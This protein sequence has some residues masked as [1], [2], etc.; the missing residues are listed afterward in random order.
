MKTNM[1]FHS[2]EHIEKEVN[3]LTYSIMFTD[4]S[5]NVYSMEIADLIVRCNVEIESLAKEIYRKYNSDDDPQSAGPCIS[6]L[7]S[8]MN[9][10]KKRISVVS[11]YCDF[12]INGLTEFAPFDY[13]PESIDNYYRVYNALKHDRVKNIKKANVYT[14]IR[15]MGALFILNIIYRDQMI[16]LGEE[17]SGRNVDKTAG[18]K[19]FMYKLAPCEDISILSGEKQDYSDCLYRVV[20]KDGEYS[21]AIRYI[22]IAGH[23]RK[24]NLVNCANSFQEYAKNCLGKELEEDVFFNSLDDILG[25]D[26]RSQIYTY[27]VSR[28]VS[29]KTEKFPDTYYASIN[30]CLP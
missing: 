6:W 23:L 17:K 15:I 21:F 24:F 27:N 12:S 19:F 8:N 20:K 11:P 10:N 22:D 28:I 13:T 30:K 2:Y 18:S 26:N 29:I 3:K 5:I 1:F 4:D 14:L 9:L 25:I 7:E 16:P